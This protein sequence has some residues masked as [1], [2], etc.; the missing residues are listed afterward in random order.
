MGCGRDCG[1]GR[2]DGRGMVELAGTS[3][4]E[5]LVGTRGRAGAWWRHR[6]VRLQ[7]IKEAHGL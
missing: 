7:V 6:E 3:G 2:E 4:M 1:W 5:E